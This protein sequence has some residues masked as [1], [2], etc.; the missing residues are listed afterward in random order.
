MKKILA[1]ILDIIFFVVTVGVAFFIYSRSMLII[2]KLFIP[3][4]LKPDILDIVEILDWAIKIII[5]FTY[6]VWLPKKM[7]NTVAGKLLKIKD[8]LGW[9]NLFGRK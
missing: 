6:F 5:F 3:V 1:H 4:E 7:G 9:K 2:C 8:N